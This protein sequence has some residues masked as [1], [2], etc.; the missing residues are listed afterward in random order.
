M[1]P[2]SRGECGFGLHRK[3]EKEGELAGTEPAWERFMKG[4]V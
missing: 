1:A 4:W 3:V 2:G